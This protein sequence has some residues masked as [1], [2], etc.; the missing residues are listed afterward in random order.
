MEAAPGVNQSRMAGGEEGG[1]EDVA[2]QTEGWTRDSDQPALL[3]PWVGV[4]GGTE[5]RL[6]GGES[7]SFARSLGKE[8]SG[9]QAIKLIVV[10]MSPSPCVYRFLSPCLPWSARSGLG[11]GKFR[12]GEVL[13]LK[14]TR[15]ATCS[16]IRC[17]GGGS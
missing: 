15:K 3:P 17:L 8:R 7:V 1:R 11:S 16:Y 12:S 2:E 6:R 5:R 13:G 4:T 14:L 9:S 10:N